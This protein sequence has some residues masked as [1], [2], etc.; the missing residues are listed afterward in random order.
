M[1]FKTP[2]IKEIFELLDAK[3][4]ALDQSI[5][6]KEEGASIRY[7]FAHMQGNFLCI[8]PHIRCINV[9]MDMPLETIRDPQ[10]LC[11]HSARAPMWNSYVQVT[12]ESDINYIMNL[13]SQVYVYNLRKEA[14][15]VPDEIINEQDLE[16]VRD[17]NNLVI[18]FPKILGDLSGITVISVGFQEDRLSHFEVRR[19]PSSSETQ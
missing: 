8:K 18:R 4:A 12:L 3:I 1:D 11:T 16:I 2:E 6:S 19:Q 13:V 15:K 10:R 7:E 5:E 14:K 9:E 17:S